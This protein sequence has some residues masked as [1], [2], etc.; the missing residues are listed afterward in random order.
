MDVTLRQIKG[1]IAI[2][3]LGSFSRAAD[4]IHVTQPALSLMIRKMEEQI[5]VALFER[6]SRHV[7]LTTAGR[8]LLPGVQRLVDELEATFDALT[9][10]TAP[11]GGTLSVASI[12][13]VSAAVLPRIIAAFEKDRP[14]VHV[15]LHD[16]MT[17]SHR[18]LQMVRAGEF[19]CAV[20]TPQPQDA[21]LQFIPWL[22]DVMNVVLPKAHPLARRR[23]VRWLEVAELPIIAT[24]YNSHVRRLMDS[25]FAS[26][27]VSL[28]PRAEVSLVP[29]A[30]GMVEAGLGVAVLP[31]TAVERVGTMGLV[32]VALVEPTVRR[33]LGFVYRAAVSPPPLV[34]DFIAFA[35]AF[36]RQ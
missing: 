16:A 2:S 27:G 3:R 28:R 21:D 24:S 20:G 12:P 32:A 8:E 4:A 35:L 1:F 7:A 11:L 23:K 15:V 17:E 26:H 13:S 18:M 31:D 10:S 36:G 9:E 22:E 25:A 33:S 5:G 14:R 29:T 34:R 30:L 19:D 6:S